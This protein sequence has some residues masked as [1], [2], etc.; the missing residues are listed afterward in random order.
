MQIPPELRADS[1]KDLNL[2]SQ[3]A[4]ERVLGMFW[5]PNSDEFSFQ[6]R[7]DKMNQLLDGSK[8]PTK[9]EVLRVVMSLYDTLGFLANFTVH[10]KILLQEIWTTKIGWD[11]QLTEALNIK[12]VRW[13]E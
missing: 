8:I 1:A 2:E 9:R 3:L 7:I 13:T 4:T 11:D 12:W 5:D 10:A 6:L